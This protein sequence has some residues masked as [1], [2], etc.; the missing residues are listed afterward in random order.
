[1][2][3]CRNHE[4]RSI[5]HEPTLAELVVFYLPEEEFSKGDTLNNDRTLAPGPTVSI[6]DEYHYRLLLERGLPDHYPLPRKYFPVEVEAAW[7]QWQEWGKY[8]H[9]ETWR[10]NVFDDIRPLKRHLNLWE[11]FQ[12]GMLLGNMRDTAIFY[13]K[14]KA[15]GLREAKHDV[16]WTVWKVVRDM[17]KAPEY[18]PYPIGCHKGIGHCTY[19]GG[20]C[21][22]KKIYD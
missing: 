7:K 16:D 20:P 1:M 8:E 12:I 22:G 17:P 15:I 5:R 13:S 19:E 4:P 2:L 11:E 6:L 3:T 21:L 18:F 10:R 9:G 14:W